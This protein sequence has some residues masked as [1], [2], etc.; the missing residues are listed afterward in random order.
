MVKLLDVNLLIALAWPTHL[1]HRAAQKWFNQNKHSGWATC[2]FTE[3][4]FV[5]LSSNPKIFPTAPSPGDVLSVLKMLRRLDGHQ[6][7]RDEVTLTDS[8]YSELL[9]N[10][11][12]VTDAHLLTLA[13][14]HKATL[15][16]FDK[17][18]A[19]LL[20]LSGNC[21]VLEVLELSSEKELS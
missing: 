14:A 13:L 20:P 7:L 18:L 6:F 10:H 11:N 19:R 1:H 3:V 9:S 8:P 17:G 4:A 5:R 12:Q 15:V 2:S 16:S 21:Q